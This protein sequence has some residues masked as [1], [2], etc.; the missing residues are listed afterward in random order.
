MSRPDDL[1][2]A[3]QDQL[4]PDAYNIY[5]DSRR[6]IPDAVLWGIAAACVI[7]FLKGFGAF[8]ELG[9]QS[10]ERLDE[11]VR[12]WKT[13]KDLEPYVQTLNLTLRDD[14][15]SVIDSA[16]KQSHAP[17]G[18]PAARQALT[19]AL[20][21]FGLHPIQLANR[22]LV[23][24][25]WFSILSKKLGDLSGESTGTDL[26]RYSYSWHRICRPRTGASCLPHFKRTGRRTT[27]AEVAGN[28]SCRRFGWPADLVEVSETRWALRLH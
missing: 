20:I 2:T 21:E 26:R 3:V 17:T 11:L 15:A 4:G 1:I 16:A 24:R 18:R 22:Q 27:V 9:K 6:L 5:P 14:V 19:E 10:R 12:R 23:Y 28:S 25:I 13:R 7:E 8:N